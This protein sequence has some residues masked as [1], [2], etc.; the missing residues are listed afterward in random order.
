MK[1]GWE[2]RK[3]NIRSFFESNP[4][5]LGLHRY[6]SITIKRSPALQID[7]Y[8]S[9]ANRAALHCSL[10]MSLI[11]AAIISLRDLITMRLKGGCAI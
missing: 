11:N 8:K 7:K 4:I 10:I 9:G 5:C 1:G 2:K 3:E 6:Q